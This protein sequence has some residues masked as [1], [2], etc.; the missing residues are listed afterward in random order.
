MNRI[1]IVWVKRRYW[2]PHPIYREARRN[3]YNCFKPG[4]P[5]V[6][7]TVGHRYF[8]N[9][10]PFD[11]NNLYYSQPLL[12]GEFLDWPGKSEGKPR[13]GIVWLDR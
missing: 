1:E 11:P 10:Q 3:R 2:W 13:P 9:G 8:L 7:I 4:R 6:D 12:P 5:Y